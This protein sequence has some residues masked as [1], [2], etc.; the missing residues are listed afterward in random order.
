MTTSVERQITDVENIVEEKT[1]SALSQIQEVS[2][3]SVYA[4]L[5]M[6]RMIYDSAL[7]TV[8]RSKRFFDEAVERGEDVEKKTMENA[9]EMTS[10]VEERASEV[11]ERISRNFRRSESELESQVESALNRLNVPTRSN[12]AELNAKLEALSKKIDEIMVV[13]A[14]VVVEQP[15]PR[16]DNLTAKEIVNKLAPLTIEELVAV[17]QYEMAQENR[18]TVLREIDRRL[19]A[20]PI[21]RYDAL[22]VDEIEPMLMTL[23]LS[24]LENVAEY[25]AAH[26]NR[27][28]LLRTVESEIE[29]RKTAVA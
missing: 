1:N 8:D 15:M 28:T 29:A 2:R 4:S 12:I 10:Q 11:Q 18:V 26:E 6:W 24:Q 21:A 13:Q 17:K 25:E 20:M 16:Y 9:K 7:N 14:E 27:V 23:D 3:K 22:T 5:G 19:E